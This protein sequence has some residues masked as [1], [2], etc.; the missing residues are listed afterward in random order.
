MAALTADNETVKG[1]LAGD[2]I[3][4]NL[5]I[6]NTEIIYKGGIV[7][8]DASQEVQMA[9]DTAALQVVGVAPATVDNT[10]DGKV[11]PPPLTGIF[12]FNNA[13][14]GAA[15]TRAHIGKACFVVDDNTVGNTSTHKVVAGLVVDVDADGVWVDLSSRAL[16]AARALHDLGATSASANE[17]NVASV[18]Q[19]TLTDST[20]GSPATTLAAPTALT[21]DTLTDSTTGSAATTLAAPTALTQDTLTDSTTGSASTTLAAQA[22]ATTHAITDSSTGAASTSTIAEVTN[23]A[24]AGS[25]DVGPTKDAIATLAAEAALA[26]TDIATCRTE[27]KNYI[28][29]LA[30]QLAKAKTD[31]AAVQTN[32]KNYIASLAAQLAKAKADVAAVQTNVKNYTASLAA[33][34]AKAKADNAA[35]V[36][37][38]NAILAILQA[39]GLM[40]GP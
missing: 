29:S 30:A 39:Q 18:T 21:Q 33:Q 14:S 5:V 7:A 10:L 20:G 25:A 24:N 34:L 12:R 28:A 8:I 36:T 26:K 35:Q 1:P 22:A 16:A 9:S 3:V 17:A 11:L 37:K 40:L 15:L 23:A 6:L 19:D 4:D 27:V 32:Q 2:A 38:I 13:T 31:V